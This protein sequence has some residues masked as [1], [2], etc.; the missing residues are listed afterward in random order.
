MMEQHESPPSRG[1]CTRISSR[2][3]ITGHLTYFKTNS[4]FKKGLSIFLYLVIQHA[5]A[6]IIC[7]LND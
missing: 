3:L 6:I 7:T 2:H 5:Q 1:A 4:I